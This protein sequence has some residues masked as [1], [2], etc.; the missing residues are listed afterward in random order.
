ME[1]TQ[2]FLSRIFNEGFWNALYEIFSFLGWVGVPIFVFLSGYGLVKKYEK[3]PSPL[4]IWQYLKHSWLKLFLLML[5]GVL[6]CAVFNQ[7]LGLG[8]LHVQLRYVAFLSLLGNLFGLDTMTPS[9]YWYFGLTFELYLAYIVLN[10]YRSKL[11]LFLCI[12]LPLAAQ[13]V[14]LYT[15]QDGLVHFNL[16]NLVG[17]LPVFCTGIYLAR[18]EQT[19]EEPDPVPGHPWAFLPLLLISSTLLVLCNMASW[20]W[21]LIHY[22]A[23]LFFYSLMRLCD[24]LPRV[25]S[26]IAFIGSYASFIFAS[27]PIARII[28][29]E[30]RIES[31]GVGRELLLYLLLVIVL[32]P[33]YKLIVSGLTILISRIH[34]KSNAS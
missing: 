25:A 8:G 27:H 21:A 26:G 32:A 14:L 31:W 19:R 22:A 11:L 10:K 29:N 13:I 16:R 4:R 7:I 3:E 30:L 15:G 9:I 17:W 6:F 20:C 28:V 5:P 33:L 24:R 1:R 12:I 2:E 23:L 34:V 18:I